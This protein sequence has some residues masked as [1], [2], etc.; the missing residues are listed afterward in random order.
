MLRMRFW[1]WRGDGIRRKV[2]DDF[3]EGGA[4]DDG[5]ADEANITAGM[6][7]GHGVRAWRTKRMM[8]TR[9]RTL[10][11]KSGRRRRMVVVGEK[12]RWDREE[13]WGWMMGDEICNPRSDV[14]VTPGPD[15]MTV[16][17]SFSGLPQGPILS[18]PTLTF[19]ETRPR[20]P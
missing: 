12:D 1:P 6:K 3:E 7:V 4:Y 10:C 13:R 14:F 2:R 17:A 19:P 5:Q 20:R 11:G 18:T 15:C 16:R 9:G 8:H